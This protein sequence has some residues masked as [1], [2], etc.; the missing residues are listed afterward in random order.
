MNLL[1]LINAVPEGKVRYQFL[2]HCLTG[3]VTTNNRG[4]T[5]LTLGT[6]L[7]TCTDILMDTGPIGIIVWVDRDEYKLLSEG[8]LP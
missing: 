6:K 5:K 7:I 2:A 1:E 3:N 4:V 8:Q